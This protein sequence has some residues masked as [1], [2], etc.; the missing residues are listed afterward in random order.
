MVVVGRN[1][2]QMGGQGLGETAQH[3][4][5]RRACPVDSVDEKFVGFL[6]VGLTP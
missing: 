5:A 6:L 1:S 4:D 2:V 3:I